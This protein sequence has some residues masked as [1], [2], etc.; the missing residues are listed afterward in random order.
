M[1]KNKSL[2]ELKQ[3]ARDFVIAAFILLLVIV[4]V[5][6]WC[7]RDEQRWYQ[8]KFEECV[9]ACNDFNLTIKELDVA[10]YMEYTK[11]FCTCSGNVPIDLD[12]YWQMKHNGDAS[13]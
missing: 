4:S 13:G 10:H 2:K 5:G 6:R 8:R 3:S 1:D 7:A 12:N 11:Y 9:M